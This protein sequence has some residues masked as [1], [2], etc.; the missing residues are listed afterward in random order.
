MDHKNNVSSSN[1]TNER[2]KESVEIRNSD[3][4]DMEKSPYNSHEQKKMTDIRS[5]YYKKV[6]Q[7]N[8]YSYNKKTSTYV[9]PKAPA[10]AKNKMNRSKS[11][12]LN[13]STPKVSRGNQRTLTRNKS[14]KK[15]LTT[16]P[17]VDYGRSPVA[18]TTSAKYTNKVA[19]KSPKKTK[20]PGQ[21]SVAAK[22]KPVT[23]V[24]PP[25]K[26]L[27]KRLE[28]H[29]P[30][31]LNSHQ[32]TKRKSPRKSPKKTKRPELHA[33]KHIREPVKPT[34]VEYIPAS[35]QRRGVTP[36]MSPKRKSPKRDNGRLSPTKRMILM[37][38][39][40]I[41]NQQKAQRDPGNSGKLVYTISPEEAYIVDQEFHH[42]M[43][44]DDIT[45]KSSALCY[46]A[47]KERSQAYGDS[48][49]KHHHK[50]RVYG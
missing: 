11:K 38:N 8:D 25:T 31:T 43:E 15:K 19:P 44:N 30:S 12:F 10:T 17:G 27:E 3:L 1:I 21:S 23:P 7:N 28:S 35:P 4:V 5:K 48:M 22:R 42:T 36:T 34:Q 40:Y 2:T 46:S 6:S 50:R 49:M 9:K 32:V 45:K 16:K 13:T 26:V 20:T 29:L 18:S 39:S 37:K 33:P 14:T 41:K 24:R 47:D